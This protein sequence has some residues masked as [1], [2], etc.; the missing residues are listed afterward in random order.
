MMALCAGENFIRRERPVG[1]QKCI[2]DSGFLSCL[3]AFLHHR[4]GAN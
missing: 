3:Y 1:F 4:S 2:A